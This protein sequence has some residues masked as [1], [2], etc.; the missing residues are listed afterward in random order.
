MGVMTPNTN[1]E[2]LAALA[3][4]FREIARATEQISGGNSDE[5]R[6][7]ALSKIIELRKARRELEARMKSLKTNR[8]QRTIHEPTNE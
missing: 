5:E 7:Q 4:N 6:V 3:A 2:V 1:A 8:H